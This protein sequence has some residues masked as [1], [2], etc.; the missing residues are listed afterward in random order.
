MGRSQRT[1]VLFFAVLTLCFY[2]KAQ[3]EQDKFCDEVNPP[4]ERSSVFYEDCFEDTVPISN[5]VVL[6]IVKDLKKRHSVSDLSDADP[7][8]VA[9]MLRARIVNF[10]PKGE[11]DF[12]LRGEGMYLSGVDNT[13]FW[14]IRFESGHPKVVLWT[15]GNSAAILPHLTN[16]YHDLESDWCSANE[17][18]STTYR[19]RGG[20]YHCVREVWADQVDV[21]AHPEK[22]PVWKRQPCRD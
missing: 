3:N 21:E 5:D 4:R 9:P 10:G 13:W 19:F 6:A 12:V 11:K 20:D 15:G 14:F 18:V 8:E 22:K 7:K 16:G 2:A 1:I 17:C